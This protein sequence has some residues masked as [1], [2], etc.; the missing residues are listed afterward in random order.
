MAKQDNQSNRRCLTVVHLEYDWLHGKNKVLIFLHTEMTHYKM[1]FSVA[2]PLAVF[3]H[4]L[5]SFAYDTITVKSNNF[6]YVGIPC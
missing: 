2:K 4:M 1:A 5:N 6:S 3:L